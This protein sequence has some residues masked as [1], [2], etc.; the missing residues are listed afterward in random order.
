M[1]NLHQIISAWGIEPNIFLIF[2]ALS[3]T[4]LAVITILYICVPFILLRIRKELIEMN[5]H[6]RTL[7]ILDAKS[8]SNAK[9]DAGDDNKPA[10]HKKASNTSSK[11][12]LDDDDIKKL[13]ATGFDIE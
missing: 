7:Y 13:K 1:D 2:L 9:T 5:K 6:L 10:Y 11:F 3:V 8:K 4:L 12:Q